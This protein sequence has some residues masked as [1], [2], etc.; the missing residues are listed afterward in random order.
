MRFHPVVSFVVCFALLAVGLWQIH[1]L[2]EN[3]NDSLCALRADVEARVEGS[4]A[5]LV[6]HPQGISGITPAVIQQGIDNQERTI[7]ALG[8]LDCD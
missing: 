6:E 5:F 3:T 2:A 1:V 4:K 8:D 7:V